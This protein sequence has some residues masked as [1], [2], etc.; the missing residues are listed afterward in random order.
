MSNTTRPKRITTDPGSPFIQCVAL[1][2]REELLKEAETLSSKGGQTPAQESSNN[3]GKVAQLMG[4]GNYEPAGAGVP[5]MVNRFADV[6]VLTGQPVYGA[7]A[8]AGRTTWSSICN[9]VDGWVDAV[10][11]AYDYMNSIQLQPRGQ[12]VICQPSRPSR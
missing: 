9:T 8:K 11:E 4:H 1:P 12:M 2:I 6:G 10:S 3:A 5:A 7:S